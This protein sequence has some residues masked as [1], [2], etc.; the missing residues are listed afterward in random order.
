ML[1]AGAAP[2]APIL[3][4]V[5]A[6]VDDHAAIVQAEHLVFFADGATQHG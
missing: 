6:K 5:F 1:P 3:D 4:G 2:P